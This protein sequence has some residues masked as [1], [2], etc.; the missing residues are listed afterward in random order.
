MGEV[1]DR[2]SSVYGNVKMKT[3]A[4]REGSLPEKFKVTPLMVQVL[5]G[6]FVLVFKYPANKSY[7]HCGYG[8]NTHLSFLSLVLHQIEE[9][10]LLLVPHLCLQDNYKPKESLDT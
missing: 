3:R 10:T 9:A 4:E 1:D 2:S 6:K 5:T 7:S 8:S